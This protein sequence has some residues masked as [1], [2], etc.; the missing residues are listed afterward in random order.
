MQ[1]P[2]IIY[3]SWNHNILSLNLI[4]KGNGPFSFK[5]FYSFPACDIDWDD[6]KA[7]KAPKGKD[8]Y[9]PVFSLWN[10]QIKVSL[11]VYD[12]LININDNYTYAICVWKCVYFVASNQWRAWSML[13]ENKLQSVSV[14]LNLN[15]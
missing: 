12:S 7:M 4:L 1:N 13:S 9:T 2:D 5:V 6:K 11:A 15:I 10:M 3:N 8:I 14:Q